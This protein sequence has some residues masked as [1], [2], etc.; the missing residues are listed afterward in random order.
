MADRW[1]CLIVCLEEAVWVWSD[2][3]EFMRKR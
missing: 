3:G 2:E 1:T